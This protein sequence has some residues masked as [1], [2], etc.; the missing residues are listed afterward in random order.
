MTTLIRTTV[1]KVAEDH[2]PKDLA[3]MLV[4]PEQFT[5]TNRDLIVNPP[6]GYIIYNTTTNKLNF[7][8]GSAWAAVTSV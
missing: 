5:T 6:T 8:N 7:Y 4:F 3:G 1:D 2:S